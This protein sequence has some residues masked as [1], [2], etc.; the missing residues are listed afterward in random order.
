M[1]M[2]KLF[3]NSDK[4]HLLIMTSENNHKKHGNYGIELDTGSEV[5]TP[6]DDECLLGVQV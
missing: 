3:L 1:A 2:N 6:S 5:I 4:T